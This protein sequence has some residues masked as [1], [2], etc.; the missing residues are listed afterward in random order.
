MNKGD[1]AIDPRGLIFESY[2]MDG[3]T[4]GECRTIFLDWALGQPQGSDMTAALET[5]KAEYGIPQPDHPMSR[6]IEEG[7]SRAAAPAKRRGGRSRRA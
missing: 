4:D 6:I 3:I 1:L 2:R 5:L 7:L